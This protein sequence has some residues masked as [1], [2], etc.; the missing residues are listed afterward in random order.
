MANSSH[1]ESDVER[2][3]HNPPNNDGPREGNDNEQEKG[4]TQEVPNDDELQE[5]AR[6]DKGW[7]KIVRKFYAIMVHCKHGHWHS[8]NSPIWPPIQRNMA[9]LDICLHF[10]AQ[11]T[12]VL[13]LFDHLDPAVHPLARN[14]ACDAQ[15]SFS[16]VI[17][18]DISNGVRY[19]R[20][21]DSF[22]ATICAIYF[23]FLLMMPEKPSELTS[24]SA[25]WL[26]PVVSTIVAAAAGAVVAETLPSPQLSLWTII[27]S[28]ILWGLGLSFSII[29][30]GVYFGRLALYRLPP[31]SII[32]STCIPLGPMGQGGFVILKLGAGAR[33]FFPI[34]N[35]L[36]PAAGNV[37]YSVGFL[38]ALIL[39]GF[40]L[41]WLCHAILAI[42]SHKRL[43]FSMGWWSS[44]FPLGVFANCT[45]Q[46][47]KEM[48][49]QF[50]KVLSTRS[51]L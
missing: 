2:A 47:S 31:K 8:L 32:L 9:L 29:I 18:W 39:W 45:I 49:S 3:D 25:A 41:L 37:F 46:M 19:H 34:N 1:E 33:K 4:V 40:G 51:A 27:A 38:I 6:C 15:A 50:F 28:Y 20:D 5:L 13:I 12:L 14:L 16:V 22:V 17:H 36:D 48:P 43:P 10:R 21:N 23:P 24:M 35:T 44:I 11:P 7:R 26:L 30:L 42:A